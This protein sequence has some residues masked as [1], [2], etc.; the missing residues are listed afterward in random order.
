[1]WKKTE[2]INLWDFGYELIFASFL[3]LKVEFDCV[4]LSLI[5]LALSAVP[6]LLIVSWFSGD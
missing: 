2:E 4:W 3:E 5:L 6:I 1:M